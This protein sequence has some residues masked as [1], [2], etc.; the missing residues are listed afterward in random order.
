[1]VELD[2]ALI[3]EVLE[4][5][6]VKL[7][8]RGKEL[9]A[10]VDK[11][12]FTQVRELA[13]SRLM[14]RVEEVFKD[15]SRDSVKVELIFDKNDTAYV[16]RPEVPTLQ[17]I[18]IFWIFKIALSD[19]SQRTKPEFFY[20]AGK[21]AAKTPAV[22]APQ[23]ALLELARGAVDVHDELDEYISKLNKKIY[24][25]ERAEL[26]ERFKISFPHFYFDKHFSPFL[27]VEFESED[28]STLHS[29]LTDLA[30][31]IDSRLSFFFDSST[32]ICIKD[33]YSPKKF[34]SLFSLLG[35]LPKFKGIDYFLLL[36]KDSLKTRIT[37]SP[38][39]QK[40]K[41]PFPFLITVPNTNLIV[42]DPLQ[43]LEKRF[44]ITRPLDLS[45]AVLRLKKELG[46]APPIA[47][48]P[49]SKS[50]ATA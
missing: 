23:N 22:N 4:S 18:S 50:E 45:R 16:P 8:I 43:K 15:E 21:A 46:S 37:R 44:P 11:R 36:L 47:G 32:S 29:V 28:T 9:V 10:L 12:D 26:C 38:P 25:K 34:L 27:K 48:I 30:R 7:V 19:A 33:I 13:I 1:M 6:L 39:L 3:P 49:R 41:G 5:H 17:F 40:H 35:S 2:K 14:S 24:S 42:I 20:A 31:V